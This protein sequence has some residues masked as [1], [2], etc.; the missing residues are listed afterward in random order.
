M[1]AARFLAGMVE[2]VDPARVSA[3]VNVADDT[4]VHGLSVSPDLDSCTY[5][6]AA[7]NDTER[8]WGLRN[9]T[10]SAMETLR[11]YADASDV[12]TSEAS[13]W[14]GLGDRDL[15]THLYRTSRLLDGLPLSAVTA[16][17]TRG[18]GIK[19]RLLPVSDDRLRTRVHTVDGRELAFQEY[20]VRER[21]DVDVTKV[22]VVGASTAGPAP[23]VME[24]IH[25]ADVVV[26]AP[27]NPVVS[28]EPVLMVPGISGALAERRSSVVR[29]A[30][31]SEVRRSR[32][33]PT[34]SW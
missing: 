13:G 28:I 25:D 16:E 29:S 22:E 4:E 15:G 32:A 31:S 27:S 20:F 34:D 1:G 30:R 21:H 8:G 23:G 7:A 12:G 24:A 10:W 3:V 17:I 14:F 5:T 33:Q 18:W 11:R 9:E 26:I 2:V 6:L 19:A